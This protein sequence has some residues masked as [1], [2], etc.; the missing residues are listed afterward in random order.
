VGG[1]NVAAQQLVECR[2]AGEDDGLVLTLHTP[3]AEV[4]KNREG[5]K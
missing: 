1:V 2:V 5:R 4:A 3:A